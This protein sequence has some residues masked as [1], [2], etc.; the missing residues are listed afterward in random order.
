MLTL[1]LL[2]A[3]S[4]DSKLRHKRKELKKSGPLRNFWQMTSSGASLTQAMKVMIPKMTTKPRMMT[5]NLTSS[6]HKRL[7]RL[8]TKP[9]PTVTNSSN[10]SNHR[11]QSLPKIKVNLRYHKLNQVHRPG[12]M[13]TSATKT[14]TTMRRL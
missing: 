4:I 3:L 5:K 6:H 9:N 8:K 1:T 14:T 10:K 2:K 11:V 12:T 7:V 13:L